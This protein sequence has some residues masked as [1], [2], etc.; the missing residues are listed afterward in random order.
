MLL[1]NTIINTSKYIYHI[2][3]YIPPILNIRIYNHRRL[4]H[5]RRLKYI[6]NTYKDCS[7]TICILND[8]LHQFSNHFE[9]NSNKF[10]DIIQHFQYKYHIS[11]SEY[12]KYY[13]SNMN[14]ILIYIDN[15]N[16]HCLQFKEYFENNN[17]IIKNVLCYN[18]NNQIQN[19]TILINQNLKYHI[20]YFIHKHCN[21]LYN[22]MIQQYQK[23]EQIESNIQ[24]YIQV[25]NENTKKINILY[26]LF[27]IQNKH[28][29]KI[30]TTFN[31]ITVSN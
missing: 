9:H 2:L 31:L 24:L 28:Y 19:N 22:H 26:N 17:I 11:L 27:C 10:I 18:I 30:E 4:Y 15:T 5:R 20:E 1:L 25:E 14:D 29:N 21:D 7:Q 8:K 23:L 3:K 16:I 12:Q 6:Q 13:K